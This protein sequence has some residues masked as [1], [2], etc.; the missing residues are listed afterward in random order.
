MKIT[1]VKYWNKVVN[2]NMVNHV[3]IAYSNNGKDIILHEYGPNSEAA[4]EFYKAMEDFSDVVAEACNFPDEMID[5]ISVRE[6]SIHQSEDK[7]GEESTE[8]AI[9]FGIKSGTTNTT[10]KAE[11]QHKYIPEKFLEGINSIINEAERYINGV[12]AQTE[13]DL[14][15][16]SGENGNGDNNGDDADPSDDNDDYF[17]D[18]G[19][20]K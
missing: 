10:S 16:P 9:I 12:R 18:N 17:S 5:K 14:S 7:E 2:N 15:A 1:K 11:L 6:I 4:P 19:D 8:Y 20:Q 13:L 3:R